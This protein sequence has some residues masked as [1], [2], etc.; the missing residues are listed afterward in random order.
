MGYAVYM[1]AWLILYDLT[2]LINGLKFWGPGGYVA[3]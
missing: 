2:I 3:D 1:T